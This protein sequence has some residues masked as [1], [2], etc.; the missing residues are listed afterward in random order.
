MSEINPYQAYTEGSMFSG[1]PIRLVV[2]LYQGALEAT[3]QA[4]HCLE[5]RDIWGRGKAINKVVA[6]LAELLSSLDEKEGG[7]IAQN[8]KRLYLYLQRR[9]IEAHSRQAAAPLLEVEKLL[10]IMLEGWRE[11]SERGVPQDLSAITSATPGIA[12]IPEEEKPYADY[13]GADIE[14]PANPILSF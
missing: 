8:L 6:I 7:E 14:E 13:L 5:S 3:R 12:K 1:Q 4:V 9:L 11:A 2:A 10:G